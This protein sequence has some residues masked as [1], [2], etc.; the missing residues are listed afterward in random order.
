MLKVLIVDDSPILRRAMRSYIERHADMEV[1]G[2]AENRQE[3]V[4]KFR[5]LRPDF[6]ILD[7][8]MPV[9]NGLEAARHISGMA[10]S[11]PF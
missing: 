10:P 9:M 4:A 11:V 3:A 1:C 6:V 5:Q 2:E 7:F 8:S